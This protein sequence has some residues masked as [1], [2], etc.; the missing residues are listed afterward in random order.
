MNIQ[1]IGSVA[2]V[3]RS[4]TYC[5]GIGSDCSGVSRPTES[6]GLGQSGDAACQSYGLV[7]VVPDPWEQY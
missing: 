5:F 7:L 1:F 2:S 4:N 6:M 3:D